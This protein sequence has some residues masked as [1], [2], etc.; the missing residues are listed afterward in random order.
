MKK[1]LPAFVAIL[2]VLA[3]AF[4]CCIIPMDGLTHGGLWKTDFW[5]W[6]RKAWL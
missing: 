5:Q 3:L 4:C 2:V 1:Y 6:L